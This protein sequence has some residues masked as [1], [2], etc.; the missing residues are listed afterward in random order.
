MLVQHVLLGV[1]AH[2]NLDLAVAAAQ[3]S[4]GEEIGGLKGD[5]DRVNQVLARRRVPAPGRLDELSPLLGGLD[6]VL[7]RFD[8]EILGF[9]VE[10]AR[11]ESWDAAV[12]L[13]G[14]TPDARQAT[15]RMLDRYASGLGRACSRRPSRSP[16]PP[17][18]PVRRADAD[19]PGGRAAGPRAGHLT[20]SSWLPAGNPVGPPASRKSGA[21]GNAGQTCAGVERIYVEAP[22]YRAVPAGAGWWPRRAT[23]ETGD[24]LRPDHHAR[25]ARDRSPTTL[26][27]A[28]DRAARALL[29][30]PIRSGRRSSSRWCSPTSRPTAP[31]MTEETFGPTVDAEPGRRPGRGGPTRQRR[32]VRPGRPRCSAAPARAMT[33]AG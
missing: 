21:H 15:V 3:T 22:V 4:P 32:T 10:R 19:G 29:G 23:L 25:P 11:A 17:G 24:R 9:Q 5:F 8:E 31:A 12:L 26:S 6:V 13:A 7:G 27:E 33:P 16:P 14:Q 1:N 20:R 2:I 18:D 30:G 28:L